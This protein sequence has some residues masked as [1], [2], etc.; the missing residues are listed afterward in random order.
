MQSFMPLLSI[1]LHETDYMQVN[2]KMELST[3]GYMNIPL[4][5]TACI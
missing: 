5:Y 4:P 2:I 3:T 1:Q